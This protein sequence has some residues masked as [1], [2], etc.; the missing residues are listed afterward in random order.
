SLRAGEGSGFSVNR[1]QG[2]G[3]LRSSS[4]F[5]DG[6]KRL[7]FLF[8]RCYLFSYLR[9]DLVQAFL[10]HLVQILHNSAESL[11]LCSCFVSFACEG[12]NV[13]SQLGD[14]IDQTRHRD[15]EGDKYQI[16]IREI[17]LLPYP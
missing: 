3:G 8:I 12:G 1:I 7:I 2:T 15:V 10:K 17:L 11:H 14:L 6:G 13:R 5:S 16:Q 4:T 9:I